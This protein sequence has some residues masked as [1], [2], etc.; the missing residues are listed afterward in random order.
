MQIGDVV[1]FNS[2]YVGTI[3]ELDDSYSGVCL[4]ISGDVSFKNPTW[5]GRDTLLR[6]AELI[7]EYNETNS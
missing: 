1:K 7:S 2:G 5:M 6:A 4:Y 3:V